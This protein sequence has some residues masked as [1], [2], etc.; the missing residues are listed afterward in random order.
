MLPIARPLL[1]TMGKE[2]KDLLGVIVPPVDAEI[3]ELHKNRVAIEYEERA[4]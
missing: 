2:D 3:E 4:V 1:I